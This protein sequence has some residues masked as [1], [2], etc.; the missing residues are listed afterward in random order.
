MPQSNIPVVVAGI[1]QLTPRIREYLLRAPSG[2]P[3]PR[4]EP[5]AHIELH[6]QSP[7]SGPIV[8]HYSL[9]G[10]TGTWDDTPDIYRIAIQREDRQRG[11]AYIHDHFVVGTTLHISPP[12]N[13]F[14]LDR[15]D[16]KTL[17]IA[18]GIGITPILSMLRS[19]VRRNKPFEM[20]YA[21]R[22]AADMA[23]RQDV[24]R[25]GGAQARI[26]IS[27]ESNQNPL[28][29]RS[30]LAAQ[31]AHTNVYVC[32]P[33][34]MVHAVQAA[35]DALGWPTGRVR[36]E[37]F[38]SGP[39]VNDVAFDVEL[40]ASGRVV[41]VGRD[42]SILDALTQAGVSVLSDCRR[43]ECGLCPLPVLDTDGELV[44]RDRY[45]DQDEKQSGETLCICVSRTT[46]ARLV[47]DA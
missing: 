9:I 44:H 14:P 7:I 34:P 21:G 40:R 18:G 8:R 32:G 4:F 25:L 28:D 29:F 45:L 42:V 6:T 12:K 27:G 16:G 1:R 39:T 13:H 24:Q 43:G 30:V 20:I 38:S 37:L 26:H 33:A 47:L 17:L 23:Y 3:L 15:R 46:G 10:G 11:S 22:N 5:G 31:P 41:H 35:A 19:V 36:S 2:A